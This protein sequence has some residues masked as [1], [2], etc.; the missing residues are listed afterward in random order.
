M[1]FEDQKSSLTDKTLY[2]EYDLDVPISQSSK[3][4]MI[5]NLRN[6]LKTSQG[7]LITHYILITYNVI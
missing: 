4:S 7:F 6:H 5:Y 3:N 1:I 2:V